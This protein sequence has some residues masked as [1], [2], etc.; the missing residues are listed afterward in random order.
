MCEAVLERA[1]L[2]KEGAKRKYQLFKIENMTVTSPPVL[3]VYYWEYFDIDKL[4]MEIHNDGSNF[5][6]DIVMP[7]R[8][9]NSRPLKIVLWIRNLSDKNIDI[10]LKRIQQCNCVPLETRVGFNQFRQLF[11]C[12][13]RRLIHILQE[14]IHMK[15]D[16]LVA[17]RVVFYYFLL[18]EHT[19]TYV[20][21]CSDDRVI[22]VNFKLNVI[23]FDPNAC[24]MTKELIPTNL[25]EHRRFVQ[26]IWVRNITAQHLNFVFSTRERG[27]KLLNPNLTVPRL[28]VWPLMVEYRPSDVENELEFN[29]NYENTRTKF[30]VKAMGYLNKM[31]DEPEVPIEDYQ[32]LDFPYVI[33]PNMLEFDIQRLEQRSFMVAIHNY[34][35]KCVE[36]RWQNYFISDLFEVTFEPK[37][38][39]VK[40]HHSKLCVVNVRAF[41]RGLFFKRIPLALEVHRV[42]DKSTK[43]AK[44]LLEE[45]ESIDDPKWKEPSYIEHIYL[46]LNLKVNFKPVENVNITWDPSPPKCEHLSIKTSNTTIFEKLFW[47]YLSESNFMRPTAS[48]DINDELSYDDVIRLHSGPLPFIKTI[49]INRNGILQIISQLIAESLRDL[50]KNWRFIPVEYA[51]DPQ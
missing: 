12:P 27:L 31:D 21:N 23:G 9:I 28:S 48:Q 3:K 39:R 34:N 5:H 11:H 17:M 18:G 4:N 20:F 26:P 22:T 16:D 43:I 13:H 1:R 50:S 2:Q 29:L 33:Y 32:C 41:E 40:P 6:H 24:V 35:Q 25:R 19:L 38:F 49:D 8:Q 10:R 44:E 37:I 47:E 7:M 15:P 36:F 51:E 14:A 46:H 30:T 45:V 42:L